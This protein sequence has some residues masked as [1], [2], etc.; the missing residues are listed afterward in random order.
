MNKK[1]KGP[2]SRTKN[3]SLNAKAKLKNIDTRLNAIIR[4]LEQDRY[5]DVKEFGYLIDKWPQDVKKYF[6]K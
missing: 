1:H 6:N 4:I 5:I 2:R 3:H